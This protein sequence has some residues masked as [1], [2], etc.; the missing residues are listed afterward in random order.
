MSISYESIEI[1]YSTT[2]YY[3]G[4]SIGKKM[5]WPIRN[6]DAWSYR[7]NYGVSLAKLRTWTVV[8]QTDKKYD[9]CLVVVNGGITYT[10]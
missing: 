5:R 3:F 8:T 7:Y 1:F 2:Y 9:D 6:R 4:Y 10:R